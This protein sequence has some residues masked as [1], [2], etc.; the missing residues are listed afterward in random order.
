MVETSL[1]VSPKVCFIPKKNPPSASRTGVAPTDDGFT[2]LERSEEFE[3]FEAPD[4]FCVVLFC[5]N[6]F[7]S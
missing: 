1:R 4:G 6:N 3:Q 5:L 2:I 7:Q